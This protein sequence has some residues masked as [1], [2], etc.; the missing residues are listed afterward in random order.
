MRIQWGCVYRLTISVWAS[1]VVLVVKEPACQCRRHKKYGFD[2][3]VR[4]IPW[5]RAWQPTP[6]FL[7][8]ESHGQRTWWATVHRVA[9]S[10]TG[11]ND[12]AQHISVHSYRTTL[13]VC[14]VTGLPCDCCIWGRRASGS[15]IFLSLHHSRSSIVKGFTHMH[16]NRSTHMFAKPQASFEHPPTSLVPVVQSGPHHPHLLE[17]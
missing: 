11:L 6:A 7:P 8:G 14:V 15:P 9:K 5:R 12:L 1:Q 10:Q 3:W 2:P 17:F 4:K 13:S 16:W